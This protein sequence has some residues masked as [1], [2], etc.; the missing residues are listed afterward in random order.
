MNNNRKQAIVTGSGKRIGR[1]FAYFLAQLGYDLVLHYNH[2]KGSIEEIK[3]DLGNKYPNQLFYPLQFDLRNWTIANQFV[4]NLP[5]DFK[6][7]N[8]LINNASIYHQN[9]LLETEPDQ[10]LDNF[11]VHCFTP[12]LLIKSFALKYKKG[13]IV[14]MTDSAIFRNTITHMPYVLSK[15]SLV[16][17]TRL[18]AV[19]LAPNIRVNAI[20]PGPVMPA[21][22]DLDNFN[23]VVNATPLKKAVD[24]SGILST[25]KFL[26]DND[27][28][29]GQIINVDSG[30]HL[31]SGR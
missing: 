3:S 9:T 31:K 29:T 18:A 21:N 24:M 1:E 27:N 17:V 8:L 5:D 25:L 30:A 16:E 22:D 20:A 6:S 12:Y 26:M 11:A 4:N 10:L 2:S 19:E 13:M 15:R 7:V 14:N 28:I 23:K